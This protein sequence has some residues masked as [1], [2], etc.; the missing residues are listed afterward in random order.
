VVFSEFPLLKQVMTIGLVMLDVQPF[1]QY[2][3]VGVV[4]ILAVLIDQARDL[5]IGRMEAG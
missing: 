2:I 4:V 5:V 1:W 3:V